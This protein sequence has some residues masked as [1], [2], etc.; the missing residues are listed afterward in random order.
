MLAT[1][2]TYSLAEARMTRTIMSLAEVADMTGV[3][4][5]T[6]RWWRAMGDRGPKSYRLGRR[7]VFDRVVVE[8]WIDA[9]RKQAV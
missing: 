4:I 9:Q 8:A 3:P 6:L 7:V 2:D 5:D 1:N